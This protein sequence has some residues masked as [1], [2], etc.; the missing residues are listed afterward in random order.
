MES[1]KCAENLCDCVWC[2]LRCIPTPLS[3]PNLPFCFSANNARMNESARRK[4]SKAPFPPSG[5]QPNSCSIKCIR[6]VSDCEIS[7]ITIGPN[8]SSQALPNFCV[9]LHLMHRLCFTVSFPLPATQSAFN[10]ALVLGTR[11]YCTVRA[12]A[13]AARSAARRFKSHGQLGRS[14]EDS[15]RRTRSRAHPPARRSSYG[16]SRDLVSGR[17]REV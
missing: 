12:P 15:Q 9:G 16:Y 10:Q 11:P 17:G 3:F 14:G 7:F 6:P 8:R 2:Y 5:V 13:L 4:T 1:P